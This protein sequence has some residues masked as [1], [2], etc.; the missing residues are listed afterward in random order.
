MRES[1]EAVQYYC[2]DLCE[3]SRDGVDLACSS[4]LMYM[5]IV[6]G[7]DVRVVGIP[8]LRDY[9]EGVKQRSDEIKG[10]SANGYP[11]CH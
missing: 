9:L 3:K 10:P 1:G 2:A 6:Y 4:C 8:K 5:A 11:G 7:D